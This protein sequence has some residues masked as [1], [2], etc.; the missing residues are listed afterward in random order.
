MA[1]EVG[2]RDAQSEALRSLSLVQLGRA[3]EA[4]ATAAALSAERDPPHV[5]MAQLWLALNQRDK[6]R[7]HALRGYKWAWADGPPYSRH[8]ELSACE[9]VLNALDEPLPVLRPYDPARVEPLPYEADIRRLLAE[10][11]DKKPS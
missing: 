4:R 6:A 8:W 11:A 2:Q 3:D 5:A 10:H 7:D 1:R 9:A